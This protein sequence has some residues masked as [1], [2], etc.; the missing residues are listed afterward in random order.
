MCRN[1]KT[2]GAAEYSSGQRAS[3]FCHKI[4][5]LV[6]PRDAIILTQGSTAYRISLGRRG[7]HPTSGETTP[8]EMLYARTCLRRAV[9]D[10]CRA[11]GRG[12]PICVAPEGASTSYPLEPQ[13]FCTIRGGSLACSRSI[14]PRCRT[15]FWSLKP[16]SQRKSF[17]S[18]QSIC[19]LWFIFPSHLFFTACSG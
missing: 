10:W 4:F 14:S 12:G 18:K 6:E 2:G 8:G 11:D 19:S 15:P 3:A 13:G 9:W 1:E 5:F 17:V 16:P 7:F